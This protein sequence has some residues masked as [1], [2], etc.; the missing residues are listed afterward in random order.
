MSLQQSNLA[1]SG[2]DVVIATTQDSVNANIQ[3]YM[4][5]A[6]NKFG[7]ISSYVY[8]ANYYAPLESSINPVTVT[9]QATFKTRA[10]GTDPLTAIKT[11]WNNNMP[12]TTDI[13]NLQN[14]H[15]IY[16]FSAQPGI[17]A[18]YNTP[19]E[20]NNVPLLPQLFEIDT[21]NQSALIT[22]L[23]KSFSYVRG[24]FDESKQALTV[25][26]AKTMGNTEAWS[27]TFRVPFASNTAQILTDAVQKQASIQPSPFTV[28][29]LMLD[30]S[31]AQ[32]VT[33]T[34]GIDLGFSWKEIADNISLK[35]INP[36]LGYSLTPS[37]G[38]N[39]PL[40]P[41]ILD[42]YEFSTTSDVK[43]TSLEL[44]SNAFVDGN[45]NF[46]QTPSSDQHKLAT[47]NYICAAN[48]HPLKPVAPLKWNWLDDINEEGS[49]NGA[50]AV[51]RHMIA[52][53]LSTQLL[54]GVGANCYQPYVKANTVDVISVDFP[55]PVLTPGQSPV[56]T[57]YPTGSTLFELKYDQSS[58]DTAG[59]LGCNGTISLE[60]SFDLA[61]SYS[62]DKL[63]IVQHLVM[64]LNVSV[65]GT[66]SGPVNVVDKMITDVYNITVDP[67]GNLQFSAP[68]STPVDNSSTGNTNSFTNW[69]WMVNQDTSE[70]AKAA[71]AL[72]G[73]SLKDIQL[74]S[75]KQFVF[76]AG[77]AFS[78][79]DATFADSGDLVGHITYA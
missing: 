34:D 52:K 14:A 50:I 24:G 38:S 54:P 77:E 55:D 69:S 31:K 5:D 18:Y 43:V 10:N 11:N 9:D 47:L 40:P 1:A 53:F 66:Y 68:Q 57:Y 33:C 63:T 79:K 59:V 62:G 45:G 15:F 27:I 6:G 12:M 28:Q 30:F 23:F 51:S 19:D 60:S 65:H 25:L 3:D 17:P 73:S 35:G 7:K 49:Y 37:G 26:N 48:N 39:N 16:A 13:T 61:V 72:V 64:T 42:L 75:L 29:Q 4:R 71:Q 56:I 76:P 32:F 21:N 74:A 22:L 44:E 67:N 8:S 58:S 46:I 20:N 41:A 36:V 2:Y 78:I 70:F